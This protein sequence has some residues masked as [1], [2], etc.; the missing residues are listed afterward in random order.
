VTE[1]GRPQTRRNVL[2]AIH[3]AGDKLGLNGEGQAP[4]NNHSLRHSFVT[5]CIALGLTIPEAALLARHDVATTAST[6]AK[7]AETQRAA[8]AAKLAAALGMS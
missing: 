6:Y 7:V 4:V 2:R 3:R 5:N 8:V 1:T